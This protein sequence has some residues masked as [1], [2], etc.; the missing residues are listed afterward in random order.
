MPTSSCPGLPEGQPSSGVTPLLPLFSVACALCLLSQ[1]ALFC[2]I[3]VL[4]EQR[5]SQTLGL[6]LFSWFLGPLSLLPGT[7]NLGRP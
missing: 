2:C 6:S 4:A 7:G 1:A 3:K 5:L